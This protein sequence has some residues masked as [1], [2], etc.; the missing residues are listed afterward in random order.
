MVWEVFDAE[1]RP[2]E[3]LRLELLKKPVELLLPKLLTTALEL[4]VEEVKREIR[5]AMAVVF[6]KLV[7]EFGARMLLNIFLIE[8]RVE[9]KQHDWGCCTPDE[10]LRQNIVVDVVNVI[11]V[12]M[13][14]V[15]GFNSPSITWKQIVLFGRHIQPGIPSLIHSPLV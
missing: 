10:W 11:F 14:V 4:G 8:S 9:A 13:F 12:W 6:V 1:Y 7:L 15:I 3:F 2:C 5:L